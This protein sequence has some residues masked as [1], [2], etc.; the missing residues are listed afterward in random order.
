MYRDGVKPDAETILVSNIVA[1]N[2]NYTKKMIK[3]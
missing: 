3:T 1:K 2:K